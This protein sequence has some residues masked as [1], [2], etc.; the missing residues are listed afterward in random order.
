MQVADLR[1]ARSALE[2]DDYDLLLADVELPDGNCFRAAG[3]CGR[4]P[5]AVRDYDER[6]RP[7]PPAAAGSQLRM[8]PPICV[9]PFAAEETGFVAPAV[10]A[11][12]S[13]KHPRGRC[14]RSWSLPIVLVILRHLA[15]L[16]AEGALPPAEKEQKTGASPKGRN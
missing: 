14:K 1:S 3:G 16:E 2:A 4:A 10:L 5:A 13:A 8:R 6:L 7:G 12:K 15:K 9:K 11:A